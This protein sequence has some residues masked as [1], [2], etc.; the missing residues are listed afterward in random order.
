VRKNHLLYLTALILAGLTAA[1][2]VSTGRAL[3]PEGARPI[4]EINNSPAPASGNAAFAL[5]GTAL[6]T[7]PV[8]EDL[9]EEQRQQ[10]IRYFESQIAVTPAKRDA[11]WRPDFSSYGAYKASVE[12]HRARKGNSANKNPARGCESA[13]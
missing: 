9:R 8:T 11:L 4:G 7:K 1:R 10:I 6:L 3:T 2:I 5:Q 12:Q 13:G